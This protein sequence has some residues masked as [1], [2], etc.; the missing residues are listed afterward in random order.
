MRLGGKRVAP[1]RDGDTAVHHDHVIDKQVSPRDAGLRYFD[2]NGAA[3][4]GAA[5][6]AED[7]G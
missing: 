5:H 4:V 7:D 2:L 1:S 6:G 3:R